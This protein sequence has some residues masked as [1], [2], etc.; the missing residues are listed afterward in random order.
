MSFLRLGLPASVVGVPCPFFYL[1]AWGAPSFRLFI[2]NSFSWLFTLFSIMRSF[3]C[4]YCLLVCCSFSCWTFTATLFEFSIML[5]MHVS[6]TKWNLFT[7]SFILR[8][9][10]FEW[11]AAVGRWLLGCGCWAWELGLL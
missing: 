5:W 9:F 1:A 10:S 7:Y 3:S 2:R 4:S 8:V 6:A 11:L